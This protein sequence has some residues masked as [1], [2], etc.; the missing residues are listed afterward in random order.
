MINASHSCISS[1]SSGNGHDEAHPGD[2]GPDPGAQ[3][4]E[5]GDVMTSH[6]KPNLELQ[7]Q[8]P[9]ETATLPAPVTVRRKKNPMKKFMQR[10]Q[11]AIKPLT[12]PAGLMIH[13]K[14][15]Q[16]ALPMPPMLPILPKLH[17]R[18][19]DAKKKLDK[20]SGGKI[21]PMRKKSSK[22]EMVEASTD[23]FVVTVADDDVDDDVDGVDE[24]M[25]IKSTKDRE[26]K[27][28]DYDDYDDV[29]GAD[30][31]DADG[32]DA[33]GGDDKVSVDDRLKNLFRKEINEKFFQRK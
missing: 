31:T 17:G 1:G 19:L 30:G 18:K 8:R 16:A 9:V 3:V 14:I 27:M 15:G 11:N 32:T 28:F 23:S 7:L 5:S 26:A 20:I 12:H 22:G 2:Q 6:P 24:K 29:F 4:T 13:P 10:F 33:D 25:D 21:V